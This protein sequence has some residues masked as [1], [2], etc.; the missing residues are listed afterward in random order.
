DCR[1]LFAFSAFPL[2]GLQ[3]AFQ[4]NMPAGTQ[5]FTANLR[6]T[7]EADDLEPLHALPGSACWVFPPLVNRKAERTD[8][9]ALLAEF[10]FRRIT[11]KPYQSYS[12]YTLAHELCPPSSS[13]RNLRLTRSPASVSICIASSVMPSRIR[14]RTIGMFRKASVLTPSNRARALST[15]S[16]KS[17]SSTTLR[18]SNVP[19][20]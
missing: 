6:Q 17:W 9:L 13:K 11:Q 18:R 19:R 14:V 20:K 10:E 3:P 7:G 16:F 2:P 15:C 4:V 12:V 5:V 8:G 1:A